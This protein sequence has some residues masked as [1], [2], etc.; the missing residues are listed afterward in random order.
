MMIILQYNSVFYDDYH[1]L[2][3]GLL[4]ALGLFVSFCSAIPWPLLLLWPINSCTKTFQDTLRKLQR[5]HEQVKKI[6]GLSL[7]SLR[8][9]FSISSFKTSQPDHYYLQQAVVIIIMVLATTMIST[10]LMGATDITYDGWAPFK[11]SQGQGPW[12]VCSQTFG[13]VQ[14]R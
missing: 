5:K 1:H 14:Q 6:K 4:A 13:F 7:P 11:A 8:N 2:F 10:Q 9:P 3:F 12:L